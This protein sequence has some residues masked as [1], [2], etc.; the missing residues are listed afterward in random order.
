[1]NVHVYSHTYAI[2]ARNTHS[3]YTRLNTIEQIGRLAE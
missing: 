2:E 3:G 1:M